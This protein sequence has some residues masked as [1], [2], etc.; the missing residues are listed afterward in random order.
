MLSGAELGGWARGAV[1]PLNVVPPPKLGYVAP[2]KKTLGVRLLHCCESDNLDLHPPLVVRFQ[3]A[4]K[5][6]A[7]LLPPLPNDP[8]SALVCSKLGPAKTPPILGDT[9]I[10]TCAIMH[11]TWNHLLETRVA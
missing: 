2:L 9:A 7:S 3:G 11:R 6:I 4:L 5:N 10:T 1:L 8:S